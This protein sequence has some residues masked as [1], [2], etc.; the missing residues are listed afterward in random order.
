MAT[1][2]GDFTTE[3]AAPPSLVPSPPRKSSGKKSKQK[4][5]KKLPAYFSGKASNLHRQQE[6][7][8]SSTPPPPSSYSSYSGGGGLPKRSASVPDLSP[9][10]GI[11]TSLLA[12]IEHVTA[13]LGLS[14]RYSYQPVPS[15]EGGAGEDVMPKVCC[16]VM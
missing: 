16:V 1:F 11:L 5:K 8:S 15:A 10:P 4:H 13:F 6:A 14:S 12:R 3:A 2:E 7:P 9:S